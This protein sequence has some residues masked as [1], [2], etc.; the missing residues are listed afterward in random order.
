MTA[1]ALGLTAHPG[2][3]KRRRV[4]F[5]KLLSSTIRQ[6]ASSDC[7]TRSELP[8][9]SGHNIVSTCHDCCVGCCTGATDSSSYLGLGL[10]LG[11]LGHAV[12]QPPI[13]AGR[14]NRQRKKPSKHEL[15]LKPV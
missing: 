1:K 4:G 5:A 2:I 8:T 15:K 6:R 7:R 3:R 10:R 14:S 9:D 11:G 13:S 12:Q